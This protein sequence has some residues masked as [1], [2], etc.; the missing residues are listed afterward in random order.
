MSVSFYYKGVG[1]GGISCQ[2]YAHAAPVILHFSTRLSNELGR[3]EA[4]VLVNGSR[5]DENDTFH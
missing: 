3:Y 5:C 2:Y 1:R 4:R